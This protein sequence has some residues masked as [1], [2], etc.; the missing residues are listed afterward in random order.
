MRKA[1]WIALIAMGLVTG[2]SSTARAATYTVDTFLDAIASANSGQ[3]Y[4]EAQLEAACSCN[5]TLLSNVDTNTFSTDDAGNRFIDVSPSTP[6]YFLLKFGT[7]N[8]G[9][10]MFFF[11]NI[12]ELTK[13][14]W[15][16][17]ILVANGLP[18]NHIRSISH[19]A[20]T[21]NVD[22]T[23][24]SDTTGPGDT[25]GGPGDVPEPALLSL[26]GAGLVGAATRLRK[27]A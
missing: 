11:Q 4:E 6:G 26:L 16:D 8:E 17:A 21:S 25:T 10:D 7:G 13:L 15:T 22:T 20:I 27:R 1:I 18:D 5:V 9:N 23:G 2:M 14:V 19:Y 12:G 3:A 24:P